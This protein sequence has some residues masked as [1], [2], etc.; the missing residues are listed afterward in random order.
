MI[1]LLII[2]LLSF[3][4]YNFP[5]FFF[6]DL[7][8]ALRRENAY[9]LVISLTSCP[10]NELLNCGEELRV[11]AEV[12]VAVNMV[13]TMRPRRIHNTP[14]RRPI[15]DLGVLSP[16]LRKIKLKLTRYFHFH[17]VH[18]HLT[19][20][21]CIVAFFDRGNTLRCYGPRGGGGGARDS[22]YERS[23]DARR[24]F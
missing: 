19:I 4:F 7:F 2:N 9:N 10:S 1:T 14:N 3:N 16:Y 24:K 18:E 8:R 17:H 12:I 6:C 21:K 20:C 11:R 15:N 23:G 22:A 13:M 5:C